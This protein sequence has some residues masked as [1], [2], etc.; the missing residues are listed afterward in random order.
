LPQDIAMK[1]STVVA[2]LLA[3]AMTAPLASALA[4]TPPA[5]AQP[6]TPEAASL[7]KLF[8][9]SDEAQLKRN[10]LFGIFRGDMRY[11]DQFG[12]Y[13]TDPYFAA[14]KAAA[15]GELRA[16][17]AIPRAKLS[18]RDQV[19]YDVFEWT[20]KDRL[21]GFTPE[22]MAATIVRPVDHFN[23]FHTFYP[24]FSSGQGAAPFRTVKDYED[25]LKRL[26]GYTTLIDRSI[27]R[28]REGMKS[29]VVQP[30]LVVDN[31]IGQLDTQIAQGVDQSIFMGP[32]QKFPEGISAADQTR[33]RAA[34]AAAVRDKALPATTRL[35]DFLKNEYRPVAR[36]TVGLGQMKG[37]PALYAQL[38]RSQTT[39]DLTPAQIHE[40]GLSEVRRIRGEMEAIKQKVG[41]QGTLPQF[42]EDIRTN[43]KFKPASKEALT[44]MYYDVG[45]RV[46]TQL[47]KLFSLTPKSKLEIK[48]TPEFREK[49]SAGGEYQPGTPDGSRPGVFYFNTY[50]LP[51]RATPGIETL[52]LHEGAPGHHFQIMLAQED[53]SLPAFQRFGGNTAYVEGWALYSESLGEELGMFGDPYQKQGNLDDEMLRAM[54]LVVDT[55][56]HSKGW[57]RDQAIQYM[58]DNS[59]MSKTD[60]TSEVERYIAIP[61]QALAYKVG[62]LKIRELRTRAEKALGPKFDIKAFHAQVLE[63]GA[64]PLAVLE[65][66]IDRWI[67]SQ[68]A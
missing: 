36:D 48:P 54:R 40:I 46:D 56:L 1:R 57:S 43:P 24:E 53:A 47:P 49:N 7:R 34:Y 29:G 64:L 32:V 23:G 35:R 14:E 26:D 22:I 41:F 21:A 61:G 15:E 9:D 67:A 12:D 19:S 25:N 60:A 16:L 45:K 4:Q 68:K 62:G 10:P 39:T 33:L 63:D 55:G 66:K 42:F 38:V 28:F 65:A 31:V 2:I 58:M 51:S 27:G 52:Y 8:A 44:Q 11:A 6:A 18:P 50:D 3:A 20:L 59:A 17:R 5:A 37:G 30:R 13:I